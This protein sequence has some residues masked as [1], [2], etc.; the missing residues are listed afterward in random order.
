MSV[1]GILNADTMISFP[2]FR[3]HERAFNMM[4]Q[5]AGRAGRKHS[6]GLVLM[7]TS[8]P[9]H[10]VVNFVKNHDYLGFYEHEIAERQRFFYPP[11]C[12]IINIY[13]KH[14]DE[15]ALIELSV[16]FSKML[17]QIFGSRILGPE[18]PMVARVQQFYIRQIV[19]KME[20]EAS[21][22]KVKEYL[23]TIY[24]NMINA[25]PRMKS[26]ILYYDVDPS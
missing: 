16:H 2:D 8:D 18:A 13:L 7:Q 1:V 23:R 24:E 5:V 6:Q 15:N 21:M 3:S 14:R 17:R 26:C 19:L 4:E 22:K 10:A 25:D 9:D 20:T 12:R 11:F